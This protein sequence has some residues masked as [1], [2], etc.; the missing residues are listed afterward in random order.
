MRKANE[1]RV[2]Y[3]RKLRKAKRLRNKSQEMTVPNKS[4]RVYVD[5]IELL[6][7]DDEDYGD[8]KG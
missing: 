2:D 6:N 3:L 4:D 8:D 1:R 5:R 7:S